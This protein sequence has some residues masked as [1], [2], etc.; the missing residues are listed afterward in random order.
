MT[1]AEPKV[2]L[3]SFSELPTLQKYM[4]H[5]FLELTKKDVPV[6]TVGSSNVTC[7]FS[8]GDRNILVDTPDSPRPSPASLLTV[9]KAAD[10]IARRIAAIEPDVVH[11]VNKHTWNFFVIRALRKIASR[12][13]IVHTFHD[14]VGHSGDAVQKGVVIYHR[15]VQRMLDAVVV[16]SSIAYRQAAELLK[17]PCALKQVPLGE[18]EE[19]PW[20]PDVN[21]NRALIFGRINAYKGVAYYPEILR[22]LAEIAP[23]VE[24]V[25]AGKASDDIDKALLD[26]IAAQP[27][28]KLINRF[29][30]ESELDGF[31]DDCGVVLMPY[32]SITQSGVVLDAYSHSRSVVAFGVDGIEQ[33]VPDAGELVEPFDCDAYARKVAEVLYNE[34][35]LLDRNHS[36]WAYGVG[37]F[38][39]SVMA[40]GLLCIYRDLTR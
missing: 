38:A 4:Y 19:R 33:Y 36:A 28:A 32:T 1:V 14:P 23:D 27:N 18:C 6:W 5:S 9:V 7:G 3:V 11:F 25:I 29:I 40:D 17:V 37:K 30:D 22:R 35:L 8:T 24:V 13:K 15:T 10:G 12:V 39:P 34:G 2:V 26:E 16:H 20:K 31:F 21:P